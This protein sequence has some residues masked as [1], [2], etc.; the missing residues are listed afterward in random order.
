MISKPMTPAEREELAQSLD[1]LVK[2]LDNLDEIGS[3]TESPD[4]ALHI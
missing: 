1:T 4:V 2:D 3:A